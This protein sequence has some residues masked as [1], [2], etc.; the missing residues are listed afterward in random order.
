MIYRQLQAFHAVIQKGTVTSAAQSLGISQPA[1]SNLLAQL[2]ETTSLSLFKRE[3]GRLIP[4]PEASILYHEIDTVVRGMGRVDQLVSNLQNERIGTLQVACTH[5]VSFGF[6][7]SLIS[8]F[9]RNFPDVDVLYQT[10]Y[11]QNIQEWV[12]S[13]LVEIGIT[14]MPVLHEELVSYPLS[15]TCQLAVPLSSPL[16]DLDEFTPAVLDNIPF[17]VMGADH[18]ISHRVRDL[19]AQAN[20]RLRTKCQT[21]LFRSLLEFVKTGMGVALI[22]PF[23]LANDDGE[24]YVVRPFTPAIQIEMALIHHKSRPVSAL[25]QKF[26]DLTKNRMLAHASN[27]SAVSG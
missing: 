22:D 18:I 7:T 6:M 24:G 13:G 19:F 25:G 27:A 14:E 26:F 23:T 1:I 3:K 21:H 17:I 15:F 8:D 12:V 10:R 5:A 16:A 20:V 2:Q 4:T 9:T 11:S